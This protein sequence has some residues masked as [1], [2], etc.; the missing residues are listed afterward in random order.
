MPRSSSLFMRA[1]FSGIRLPGIL[2]VGLAALAAAR[3]FAETPRPD[4]GMR[5]AVEED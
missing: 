3:L 2:A 1:A 5:R 4:A